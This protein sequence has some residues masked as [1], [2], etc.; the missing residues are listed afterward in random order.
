MEKIQAFLKISFSTKVLIPVVTAMMLLVAL[1]AWTVNRLMT[2]QFQNEAHLSLR[3]AESVLKKSQKI[4]LNSLRLRFH[5]LVNEPRY[6]AALQSDDEI[7]IRD[8]IEHM[9]EDQDDVD[10]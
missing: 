10:A 9:L 3:S 5:N 7:T 6:R 8:Q 2:Q 1:T 4:A